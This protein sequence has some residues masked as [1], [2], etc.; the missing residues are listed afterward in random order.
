MEKL[1]V[2]ALTTF[3]FLSCNLGF[4]GA[5]FSPAM[6]QTSQV[7][8]VCHGENE[9]VCQQ[10]GMTYFEHC[11][12]DNGVGGADPVETTKYLCGTLP[13]GAP[14]GSHKNI[15]VGRGGGHCGYSWFE[16]RCY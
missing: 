12:D 10:H 5:L 2:L 9:G 6:A 4:L 15:D 11:G 13:G 3:G 7:Y 16:V 1:N 8:V 14:R